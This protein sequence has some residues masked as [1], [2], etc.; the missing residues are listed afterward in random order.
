MNIY[1]GWGYIYS[2][3]LSYVLNLLYCR[4]SLSLLGQATS[5]IH[6]FKTSESDY[7]TP[8]DIL[9]EDPFSS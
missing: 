3:K 2:G 4:S 1:G 7:S 9:T 8:I 6:V 5:N